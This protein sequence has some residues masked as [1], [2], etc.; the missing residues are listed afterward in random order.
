[1]PRCSPPRHGLGYRFTLPRT[2]E[3]A[4]RLA[5]PQSEKMR[6]TDFCNCTHVTSTCSNARLSRWRR[7]FHAAFT[8]DG[9]KAPADGSSDLALDGAEASFGEFD[10]AP[11]RRLTMGSGAVRSWW[12]LSI[13]GPLCRRP[14]AAALSA[15]DEEEEHASDAPFH[16][17]LGGRNPLRHRQDRFHPPFVKR[18]GFPGPKRLPSTSARSTTAFT[19]ISN[20]NPPPSPDFAARFRLPNA[21][22]PFA[23]MRKG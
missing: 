8:S 10:H 1:V 7:R 9:A 11:F 20:A 19:M 16:D 12:G 17:A 5:L 15:T 4:F 13:V 6:L 23:T 22:S 21:L 3:P 18:G 14:F 2:V